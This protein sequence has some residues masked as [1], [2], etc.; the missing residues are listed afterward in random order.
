MAARTEVDIMF[1]TN[2]SNGSYNQIVQNYSLFQ[3]FNKFFT[4]NN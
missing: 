4:E 3:S 1:D 2:I